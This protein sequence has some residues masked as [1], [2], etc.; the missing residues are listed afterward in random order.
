MLYGF[1]SASAGLGSFL[2]LVPL[3]KAFRSTQGNGLPLDELQVSQSR[4]SLLCVPDLLSSSL[5][6]P[7]LQNLG[8]DVVAFVVFAFLFRND[9]EVRTR[10]PSQASRAA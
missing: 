2:T 6:A 3:I 8:I 1:F 9:W 7:A 5:R 10:P 4:C